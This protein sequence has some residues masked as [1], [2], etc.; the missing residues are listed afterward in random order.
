MRELTRSRSNQSKKAHTL[1]YFYQWQISK[2]SQKRSMRSF[3]LSVRT[4]KGT[5]RESYFERYYRNGPSP[6]FREI[7]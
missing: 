6:W 7:K 3:T 2:P 5:E 1:K 4:R